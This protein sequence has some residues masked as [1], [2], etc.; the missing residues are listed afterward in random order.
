MGIILI[1]SIVALATPAPSPSPAAD[2]CGGKHTAL[3]AALNRPTIGYSA[4]AVKPREQLYELGYANQTGSAASAVSI[5]QGFLRFGVERAVELDVIGPA[6]E[7]ARSP[8][9][10]SG[11]LDAGIGAKFELWQHGGSV[12]ATD[13]LYTLPTGAKAFSVH[14]PVETLN[15]DYG[16]QLSSRLGFATTVGLSSTLAADRNG[17]S[18]RFASLLPSA[19]F[20]WQTNSREQFF[21]EAY[22]QTR[23][24][25]DGGSLFGLDGG[26]QY[27]LTPR[28][29]VD[30]EAGRTVTD[31][32]RAHYLGFGVGLLF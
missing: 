20:T 17:R 32:D 6:Y 15:L 5:P 16:T 14:G 7:S 4:C 11:F 9:P 3:L 10:T 21:A 26:F 30:V 1:S 8:L 31:L 24:R 27:L 13:L 12:L 19:V 23:L 18:G 25:P 22:G 2:P 28:V 29:E